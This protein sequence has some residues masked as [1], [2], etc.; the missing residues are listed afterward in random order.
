MQRR[1]VVSKKDVTPNAWSIRIT[2]LIGAQ[3]HPEIRSFAKLAQEIGISQTHL[4]NIKSGKNL[5]SQK[6]VKKFAKVFPTISFKGM[7]CYDKKM[8]SAVMKKRTIVTKPE[9]HK[10]TAQPQARPGSA[11]EGVLN[12]IEMKRAAM[13]VTTTPS[14]VVEG[15]ND[16]KVVFDK[17][18]RTDPVFDRD[19]TYTNVIMPNG[20]P[21]ALLNRLNVMARMES[22]KNLSFVEFVGMLN[23]FYGTT[24]TN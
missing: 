16:V 10:A 6:V 19:Q 18:Q 23:F 3:D 5:P 17:S 9:T 7:P 1:I 11:R 21:I 4:G 14:P 20:I 2:Q 24:P 8:R 15:A 22:M 13:N 12:V